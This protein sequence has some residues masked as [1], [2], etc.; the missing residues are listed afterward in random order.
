VKFIDDNPLYLLLFGY[1]LGLF[2]YSE[3]EGN[4]LLRIVGE[5]LPDY[6]AYIPEDS[7]L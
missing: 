7:A 6:T 5:L 4:I 2:F 3:D 1:L